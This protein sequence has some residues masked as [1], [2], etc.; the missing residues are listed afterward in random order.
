MATSK[1]TATNP[2]CRD[3]KHH[4]CAGDAWD[5][6]TDQPTRCACVCHQPRVKMT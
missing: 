4:A 1:N 3:G 2:D 5:E 6:E